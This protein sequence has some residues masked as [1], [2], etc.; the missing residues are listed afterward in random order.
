MTNEQG[1]CTNLSMAIGS[2]TSAKNHIEALRKEGKKIDYMF[3]ALQ[4]IELEDCLNA[5]AE[6]AEE[7]NDLDDDNDLNDFYASNN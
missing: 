1:L 6:A 2:L 3:I 7:D 5:L 4:I